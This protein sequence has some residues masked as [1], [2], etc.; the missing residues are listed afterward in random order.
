MRNLARIAEYPD[1]VDSQL[2]GEHSMSFSLCPHAGFWHQS[3]ITDEAR[4]Y[5]LPALAA[6][7]GKCAAP[8]AQP[9]PA[10]HS[11][12]EIR[13][14]N[15]LMG[16]LKRSEDGEATILRVV[17]PTGSDMDAEITFDRPVESVRAVLADEATPA[18]HPAPT[19]EGGTIRVKMAAKKIVTL[20]VN[21]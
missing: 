5:L 21:L 8:P 15:L 19:A 1:Q 2:Q 10:E 14:I 18:E 3:D 12:L 9:L 11:F 6:Q 13:P 16:A 17:N 20:R 4:R 7:I